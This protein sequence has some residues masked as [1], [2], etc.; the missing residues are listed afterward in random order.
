MFAG[1][2]NR[3]QDI[4]HLI[5]PLNICLHFLVLLHTHFSNIMNHN[6][7]T[8]AAHV[9]NI[10]QSG[11]RAT[12]ESDEDLKPTS[13]T[14]PCK[15]CTDEKKERRWLQRRCY[16]C[17]KPGHQISSCKTKESDEATQPLQLAINTGIQQQQ[18]EGEEHQEEFI[19][20]GTD[21]G[22]WSEIWYVSKTFKRHFSGNLDMFK[23]FKSMFGV[24]TQTGENNFY[25]I[26]GIG[27]VEV[28]TGSERIRIQ[29]VFYTPDI[30]RNVLSLDQLVTQGYTVKFTGDKC[31]IFPTFS[32][33]VV[34]RRNDISSLTREDE[35]GLRENEFM[36]KSEPD[37]ETFKTEYLNQY[38]E[39]L[40]IS[41]NE[42][43]WNVLIIQAM[44]FKEFQDCKALLDMLEDDSYVSKYKYCIE[45]KFED[46][47][48]WFLKD[49]LEIT[50]RP[51]PAYA[52]D[53]RKE[54]LL[55]LYMT[56]KREGG[57]RRLTE[58]NMWG[59]DCQRYG[60]RL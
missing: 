18:Q 8:S 28:M 22:L 56:V 50:T 15:H 37:Y 60:F 38:F 17:N 25:F 3:H 57:H 6:S 16:Y 7:Q 21:D 20:T 52:A 35:I 49:K 2:C 47:V 14:L 24:E 34:N 32:V 40:D 46:M 10:L 9:F 59:N 43:D 55:E 45:N 53:N 42:P 58:N 11:I 27:V 30:N 48:D 1:K 5:C 39:S 36:M 33:P 44:S 23:L 13:I 12:V 4:S 54:S 51:L 29:S 41:S 26:K 19:V 31:K